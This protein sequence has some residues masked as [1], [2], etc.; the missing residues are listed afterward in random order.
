LRKIYLRVAV[1][2][3][4]ALMV[5]AA[6][7]GTASLGQDNIPV[8]WDGHLM[9]R[10]RVAAG[11]LTPEDR[12][13]EIQ[14]RLEDLMADQFSHERQDLV[15]RIAVRPFGGEAVITGPSGLLLT[16]TQADA[17]A[18]DTTIPWLAEY[19]RGRVE[20]AMIV[21]TQTG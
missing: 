3:I 14:M 4:G 16:V 2:L 5:L 20:A 15:E 7:L 9:L 18:N 1:G 6:V 8:F 12:A 17:R 10:V 13:S 11:G 19:W 21:A